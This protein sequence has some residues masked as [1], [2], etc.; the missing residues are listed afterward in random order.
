MPN[1]TPILLFFLGLSLLTACQEEGPD[2][3]QE[4]QTPQAAIKAFYTAIAAE[5][6][7]KAEAFCEPSSQKQLRYFA[8]ELQFKS[9][10]PTQKEALLDKVRFDFSQLD[11]QEKDGSTS[12]QLCCNANQEAVDIE[13]V[14]R[15]GKWLVVANLD[16]Y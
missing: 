8:T 2:Y 6:F 13:M 5:D 14:Q 4:Q 11:C 15:E 16:N 10:K 7:A 9:A 1:W 12:C 3:S